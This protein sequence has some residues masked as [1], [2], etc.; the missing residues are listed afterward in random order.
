MAKETINIKHNSTKNSSDIKHS[1]VQWRSKRQ[2]ATELLTVIH[3][4]GNLYVV[5]NV[6]RYVIS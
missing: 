1:L 2:C 4:S 3:T 6:V 5:Y